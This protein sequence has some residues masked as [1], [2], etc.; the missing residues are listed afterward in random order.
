MRRNIRKEFRESMDAIQFSQDAKDV[1]VDTLLARMETQEA[2]RRRRGKKLLLVGLAAVLLLGTLTGAAVFTRWS[3]SAQAYYNPSQEIK[4]Q[5]EK[6]GLSV[7]LET[8][9]EETNPS[10]VLSATD[11]G[12]TVT[13]VQSIVDNYEAELTFRIEGFTLPEGQDPW[14][15]W[16]RNSITIDGSRDFSVS[17]T[18]GFYDGTTRDENGE[19]VYASNGQPVA[20]RDDEFQSAILEWVA[21]DGSMEYTIYISF[22][23]TSGAYLGK[24]IAVHFDGFG[25]GPMKGGIMEEKLV[26]GSWDLHW[27]L[28][29]ADNADN[30]LTISPNAEIGDSGMT[31]LEAEIGQKTIRAVYQLDH[32]WDGWKELESLPN[33]L[34]AV[35]MKNGDMVLVVPSG[36]NYGKMETEHIC[37]NTYSTFG[38]LIDISQVESLAFHK[39]WEKDENGKPTIQTF[40]YVPI[41]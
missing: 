13:L 18:G 3:R 39:G 15:F 5:A 10:E 25:T 34:Q 7:M 6:S 11:Q 16:D 38:G 19:W 40:Y 26:D 33:D 12:V 20:S 23:D 27:T 28:T 9:T 29:G 1:M 35:R 22:R 14:A 17:K 24:E 21:A 32:D 2:P 41:G 8:K 36:G 30:S 4:E 31:L 37:E